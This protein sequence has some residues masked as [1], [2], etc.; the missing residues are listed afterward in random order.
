MND[1]VYNY[2]VVMTDGV[3]KSKPVYAEVSVIDSG[4]YD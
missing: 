1:V 2:S 3:R 4:N